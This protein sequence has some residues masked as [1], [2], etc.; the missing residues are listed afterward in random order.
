MKIR[1]GFVS[2]SSSSSF[3]ILGVLQSDIKESTEKLLEE[4]ESWIDED[5]DTFLKAED[6]LDNYY[7]KIIIGIEPCD[8]NE[9]KTIKQVKDELVIEFAKFGCTVNRKNIK[10]FIDG[11]HD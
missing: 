11:G 8:I 9:N 7:Q 1:T 4:G 2:N 10:F 3:C 5:K 6:G